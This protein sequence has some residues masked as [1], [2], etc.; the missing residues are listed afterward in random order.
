MLIQIRMRLFPDFIIFMLIILALIEIVVLKIGLK[1]TKAEEKTGMKWVLV[2]FACQ[3]G[4]ILFVSAPLILMGLSGE[5]SGEDSDGMPVGLIFM[6]IGFGLFMDLQI[7]NIIHR[8]GMKKALIV[9]GLMLVPMIIITG[10]ILGIQTA[11]D[12]ARQA[13]QESD[14]TT[15]ALFFLLPNLLKTII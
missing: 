13:A 15:Q 1:I 7:L 4:M 12:S 8:L 2:S 10:L 6:F 14:E 3:V 11:A 5:F 9:F